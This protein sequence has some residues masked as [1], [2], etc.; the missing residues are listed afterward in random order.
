MLCSCILFH[1]TFSS[2]SLHHDIY[3]H[4]S[5]LVC[6]TYSQ[7]CVAISTC[8]A[9]PPP[10][11]PV[12]LPMLQ[13]CSL[14]YHTVPFSPP[15]VPV[16]SLLPSHTAYLSQPSHFSSPNVPAYPYSLFVPSEQSLLKSSNFDVTLP[17]NIT[18]AAN[19]FRWHKFT[20]KNIKSASKISDSHYGPN[21]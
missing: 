4:H 14:Y 9:V 16:G 5:S 17:R 10:T 20:S 11:L 21:N 2:Y 3:P 6:R 15:S 18:F 1:A 8:L 12:S 13:L 19:L 7:H